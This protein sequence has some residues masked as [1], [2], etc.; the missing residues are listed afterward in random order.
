MAHGGGLNSSG[1]HKN[2]STGDY[3]C[4]RS[5]Y[6]APTSSSNYSSRYR[7]RSF[8]T[9]KPTPTKLGLAE[10]AAKKE[11]K[12]FSKQQKSKKL[13]RIRRLQTM[14]AN[15]TDK[16]SGT[17]ISKTEDTKKIISQ[18]TLSF[19]ERLKALRASKVNQAVQI[20]KEQT[21]TV[22]PVKIIKPAV[23]R[24]QRSYQN[25]NSYKVPS[26]IS[27]FVKKSVNDICHP[28]GGTYYKRTK[29]YTAYNSMADCLKSGAR[30]SRR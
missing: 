14:L 27:G 25:R 22:E 9:N 18:R 13:D 2:H 30:R 8:N 3:H 29:N 16:S 26:A 23:S 7:P 1:C 28:P 21:E 24:I 12:E 4:H 19:R 17:K 5:S 6:S 20:K 10:E 11:N 15:K